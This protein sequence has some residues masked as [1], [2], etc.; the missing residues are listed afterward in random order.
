MANLLD[1]HWGN[2]PR[3]YGFWDD[4][5]K[6]TLT[7]DLW[8]I[9]EA[10]A[11]SVVN[12]V[13]AA[14]GHLDLITGTVDE[15]ETYLFTVKELFKF[16]ENKPMEAVCRLA[17]AQGNTS[18]INVMFGFA[19]AGAAN[20]LQDAGA[21]PLATYSGAVFFVEELQTEWSVETSLGTTQETTRL[22]TVNSKDKLSKVAAGGATTFH[23]LRIYVNSVSATK[24]VADFFI[25]QGNAGA[26]AEV[27]VFSQEFTYTSATEMDVVVGLKCTST[28]T[29]KITVD[30]IGAR[31]LR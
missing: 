13:D 5:D 29:E 17:F 12:E 28:T 21:G 27:H 22:T 15:N 19:S 31:Q 26:A 24:A 18:K 9:L 3:Q 23:E 2:S 7:G 16:A 8:T 11:G 1:N 4:F 25:T 10:D 6:G 14:G 30:Y 20:H